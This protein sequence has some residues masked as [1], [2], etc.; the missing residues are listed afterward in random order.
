MRIEKLSELTLT[1]EY[2]EPENI[3]LSELLR[4]TIKLQEF[5]WCKKKGRVDHNCVF[6]S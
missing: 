2:I 6:Q 3:N 1:S 5:F 4:S